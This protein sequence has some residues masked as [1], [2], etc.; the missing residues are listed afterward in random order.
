MVELPEPVFALAKEVSPTTA[1]PGDLVTF[2]ITFNNTGDPV[3][4]V[5][6]T[7]VL[8][9]GVV[10]VSASDG[11]VYDDAAGTVVWSD[12]TVGSEVTALTVVVEIGAETVPGLLTNL[13]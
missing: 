12:L 10:F 11:G 5:T 7:D 3:D 13:V 4:G 9:D 1:L 8:P 2:T 6:L